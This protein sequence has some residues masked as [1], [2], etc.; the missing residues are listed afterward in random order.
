MDKTSRVKKIV[1]DLD[2]LPALPGVVNQVLEITANPDFATNELVAVVSLDPGVTANVLR[3]ANSAY[4]GLGRKISTL[5]QALTRI[6][7]Q[8]LVDITLNS[9]VVPMFNSYLA[10]YNAE[11]SQLWR[12]SL[13]SAL[14]ARRLAQLRAVP[15]P[16][17]VY[18]AAL[19]HDV[20]KLILSTF[21]AQDLAA[22][23]NLIVNNNWP[24]A[25]AEREVLGV[26]HAIM[27][28]LAA[29][30][31]HLSETIQGG[32]FFHHEPQ[33][34]SPNRL[35]ANLIAL[36]NHLVIRCGMGCGFD[37]RKAQLPTTVLFDLAITPAKMDQLLE[38]TQ[39][40]LTK[41]EPLFSLVEG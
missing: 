15:A 26:D 10:G 32:I 20:G 9:G 11:P 29:R 40:I 23:G 1:Q 37:E 35:Y 18:T 33:K 2:R 41:A 39:K 4:F 22:I 38:E 8:N 28:G 12:H 16:A 3:R 25:D 36:A 6:G 7:V 13:A 31:W 34:A 24:P 5:D 19:L 30:K 21:L 14:V 17:E 27:G